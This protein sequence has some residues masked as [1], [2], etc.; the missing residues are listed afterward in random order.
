MKRPDRHLARVALT[1][2]FVALA[3]AWALLL[4]PQALGGPAAY[5]IVSGKSMEPSLRNGDLVVALKRKSYSVGDVVAYRIPKEE[6][7]A[8]QLVIHRITGGSPQSGYVLQGDNRKGENLW[9][10]KP[11]DIAG[12]MRIRLPRVGLLFTFVRT[13][14]GMAVFAGLVAFFLLSTGPRTRTRVPGYARDVYSLGVRFPTPMH[15]PPR[16]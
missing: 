14:F 10:P 16:R 12:D 13:P 2:A 9:R 3:V 15:D 1:V 11:R 6:P 8:G 4:R 5:V 7:G